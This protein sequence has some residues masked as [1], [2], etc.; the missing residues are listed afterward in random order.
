[1]TDKEFEEMWARIKAR[2]K[3]MEEEWEALP[4]EEKKRRLEEE[5]KRKEEEEKK[6]EQD[7]SNSDDS[8]TS[9]KT[10]TNNNNQ[11]PG[12][13]IVTNPAVT[14]PPKTTTAPPRTTTTT[15]TTE[16]PSITAKPVTVSIKE[17]E[18]AIVQKCIN[19][20]IFRGTTG[21]AQPYGMPGFDCQLAVGTYTITW[22]TTNGLSCTQK[23]T[24]TE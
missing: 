23:L 1:M 15:T 21:S 24:I 5:K 18:D 22:K 10:T 14:N 9:P 12:G 6:K 7:S 13:N 4:E 2:D 16:K 19:N 17:G 11:N 3:R 20:V 8:S